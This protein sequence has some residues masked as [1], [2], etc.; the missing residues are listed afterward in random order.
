MNNS[1][2][3][4]SSRQTWWTAT[5]AGMAS[6]LDAAAIVT[7]GTALVLFQSTFQLGP[8]EIGQL[9]ALLTVM[10]AV[11]ALVGGRLGDR[12]G[13]RKVFTW[14]M[15]VFALGAL[16]LVVATG[17]SMLYAGV[18]LLGFAAGADLP[19]SMAMISESAPPGKKG[20]MVTFSHVL[21]MAGVLVVMALGILV[22][23]LGEVGA[24][25]LYG[26][27][28]LVAL[29][30][31][32]LRTGLP[33]SREWTR[34]RLE[35]TSAHSNLNSLRH[36]VR[37]RYLVPLVATGLF[38]SI[39]NVAANTNGQFSTYLYIN[40][41]GASVATASAFGL[42]GFGCSFIGMFL[43]MRIVD[44]RWRMPV[45]AV[46]TAISIA[47]FI[48]PAAL[49]VSTWT[50][51]VMGVLYSVGGAIAGEPMFKVWSQE[52]FPTSYRSSAQGIT[53]A[54]TRIVAAAIALITPQIISAGAQA[55][56]IFLILT[57]L[58]SCLIGILWLARIPKASGTVSERD[59]ELVVS[60]P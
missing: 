39:A 27:L 18:V 10:I 41:A 26:H 32:V 5:I 44:T 23:D 2:D 28:L 52:L 33:E 47:A 29:I 15:W 22:G 35:T 24:R 9:S 37:S 7:T 53:I 54:F 46:A 31:L 48:I 58:A 20:K 12:F 25:I 43:T 49:G 59:T 21:W 40:V 3:V 60:G 55:L 36:L 16:S 19:V 50:L 57:T 42:L 30:V 14:T 1:T 6:Y 8:A 38:Y 56:F 4:L 11:G 17:P 45:F 13:R 51:A 34:T